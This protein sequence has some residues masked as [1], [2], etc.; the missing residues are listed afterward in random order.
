MWIAVIPAYNEADSIGKVLHNLHPCNFHSIILVAN[1]CNDF[2]EKK[3]LAAAQG[4]E[5][6]LL[7]FPEPLGIDI[8]RAV[9]AAYAQ[10]YHPKGIVFVDGDM[11]GEITIPIQQLLKGLSQGLDLALTNCYP[12]FYQCCDLADSVKKYR[13]VVNKR[14][15]L[16]NKI[17]LAT[18]SHGPHAISANLLSKIPNE[19]LAV[20][21]LV[22]C[23]AAINNFKIN[24][25][26]TIPHELLGSK[27]R[28]AEHADNIADTIIGD[29]KQAL[30][31]LEGNSPPDIREY[32]ENLSTYRKQR[33]FDLL[34]KFLNTIP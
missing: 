28:S 27:I 4:L 22:L 30:A 33:R 21:P 24:V 10:K 1:G 16:Y 15:H 5:L 2:T 23:F 31:Y 13:E 3:A 9:G 32:T 19:F 14:L 12:Y 11:T 7:S 6:E 26:A 20:P 8:P 29:C 25:A 18:P 17:G 34:K